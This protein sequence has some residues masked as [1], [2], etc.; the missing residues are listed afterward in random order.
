MRIAH[1]K[2]LSTIAILFVLATF[3]VTA[4]GQCAVSLQDPAGGFPA[5][6]QDSIKVAFTLNG[7]CA[8][9]GKLKVQ[10]TASPLGAQTS[11]DIHELSAANHD[12][13]LSINLYSG[14]NTITLIGYDTTNNNALT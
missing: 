4:N 6:A 7:P 2:L 10:V 14:P 9:A 3:S 13:S 5:T 11:E 8:S 12:Y 1:P